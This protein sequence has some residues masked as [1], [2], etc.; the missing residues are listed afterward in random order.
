PKHSRA[1]LF[2]LNHHHTLLF[3]SNHHHLRFSLP[4]RHGPN[5]SK[6]SVTRQNDLRADQL[7]FIAGIYF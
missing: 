1:L 7:G 3:L 4:R 6:I 2:L 5:N